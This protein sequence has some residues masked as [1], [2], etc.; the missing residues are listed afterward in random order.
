ML[1]T[2]ARRLKPHLKN[3]AA[4]GKVAVSGLVGAV[5]T[6]AGNA[7]EQVGLDPVK[8]AH[9]ASDD[10]KKLKTTVAI[11]AVLGVYYRIRKSP[12][13]QAAKPPA[14]PPAVGQ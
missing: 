11:G 14:Q 10:W 13:T 9:W 12:Y 4:H 7:A 6:G 8:M 2:A 5:A 3:W 1:K